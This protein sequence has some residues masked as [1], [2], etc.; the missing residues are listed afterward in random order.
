MALTTFLG[1]LNGLIVVRT[2]LPSF[3]VTLGGLLVWRGAA[4]WVASGQ[5]I[6]PLDSTFQLLGGGARGTIGATA[7]WIV[8]LLACLA[9]VA[10]IVNTRRQRR[11]FRE[12]ASRAAVSSR[13]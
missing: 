10:L 12:E 11:R 1:V 9:V 8:G 6:A 3:I 13:A 7:S 4:W 2:G 5:T